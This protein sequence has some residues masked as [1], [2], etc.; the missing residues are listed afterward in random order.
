M[1]PTL[2]SHRKE[3]GIREVE[4]KIILSLW[5]SKNIDKATDLFYVTNPPFDKKKFKHWL[6]ILVLWQI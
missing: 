2:V 1:E 6:C 4:T 5:Q 3:N